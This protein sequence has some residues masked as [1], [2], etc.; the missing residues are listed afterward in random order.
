MG[1]RFDTSGKSIELNNLNGDIL[2]YAIDDTQLDYE[3]NRNGKAVPNKPK[4]LSCNKCMNQEDDVYNYFSSRN[5]IC[6]VTLEYVIRKDTTRPDDQ[7][8][9]DVQMIYND[10][11]F[12]KYL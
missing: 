12:K 7:D 6:D 1:D 9:R 3:D 4:E 11:L 8:K 5:I 10:I 2:S